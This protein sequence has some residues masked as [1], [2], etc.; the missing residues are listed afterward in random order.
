MMRKMTPMYLAT[1]AVIGFAFAGPS[2]AA[3]NSGCMFQVQHVADAKGVI[4]ERTNNLGF[5]F[6][7]SHFDATLMTLAILDQNVGAPPVLLGLDDKMVDLKYDIGFTDSAPLPRLTPALMSMKPVIPI[8]GF[9][10]AKSFQAK[11]GDSG[12]AGLKLA[13]F[14]PPIAGYHDLQ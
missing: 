13:Q 1:A 2:L 3:E 5:A 10:D 6:S 12:T 11:T 4:D 14:V 7:Q 8:G 9:T